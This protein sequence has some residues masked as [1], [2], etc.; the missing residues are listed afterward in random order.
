MIK[1]PYRGHTVEL[2]SEQ[3]H[4]GEWIARATI[5]VEDGKSNK[6]IPILGRR[7]ATFD[8]RR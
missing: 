4:P 8:T 6:K 5:I 1:K 2:T 7:R 3:T